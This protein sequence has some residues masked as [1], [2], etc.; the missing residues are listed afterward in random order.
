MI[1]GENGNNFNSAAHQALVF[2]E[3]TF[4]QTNNQF[5]KLYEDYINF[6]KKCGFQIF[7][8]IAHPQNTLKVLDS[9]LGSIHTKQLAIGS[10]VL[11]SDDLLDT[12]KLFII[13]V[14]HLLPLDH[15]VNRVT[16]SKQCVALSASIRMRFCAVS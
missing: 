8:V 3:K 12:R 2:V 1:L 16:T 11:I 15:K 7:V 10:V 9:Q 4:S 13:W 5:G 14:S 6:N